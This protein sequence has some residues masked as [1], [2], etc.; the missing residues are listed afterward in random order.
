MSN[1]KNFFLIAVRNKYRFASPRGDL[2]VEQLFDLPL[3]SNSGFDLD[4]IA[5]NINTALKAVREES[6]VNV[7]SN[8]VKD[9]AENMLETVKAV[10][11]IKQAEADKATKMRERG[12][13]RQRIY[14]VLAQK[15]DQALLAASEE[16]LLKELEALDGE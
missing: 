5:K 1:D 10:I 16:D 15:K 14:E 7:T 3:S 11:T 13:K 2:T 4:T 9:H 12:Q 6:F 8:P